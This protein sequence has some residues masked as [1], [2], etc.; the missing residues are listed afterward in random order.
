MKKVAKSLSCVLLALVLT[1]SVAVLPAI[2]AHADEAVDPPV[3]ESAN[4]D[5]NASV[6]EA[7]PAD[8]N[9]SGSSS[10]PTL[11]VLIIAGVVFVALIVVAM[12][13]GLKTGKTIFSLILIAI[14]VVLLVAVTVLYLTGVLSFSAS[15]SGGI[16]SSSEDTTGESG[17]TKP[18]TPELTAENSL[19]LNNMQV[20]L[21]V[22]PTEVE[23]NAAKELVDYVEKMT[24]KVI[25]V[26]NEGSAVEAGIYVGD[27]EFAKTNNVTYP[28][29]EYG[30]GWA[31]KVVD[32]NL[33]L[34]G[35]SVRGTLYAV[36]H[37]LEDALGVHWWTYTEEYV[38]SVEAALVWNEY[39]D[40]GAPA[41]KYREMYPGDLRLV[42][43]MFQVRN[44]INGPTA[45]P[46][47]GF[48]GVEKYGSPVF[49]H[50]FT[51]YV[52]NSMFGDH[53][54]W[55]ALV[56]GERNAQGQL[57]MTNKELVEHMKATLLNYIATDIERCEQNGTALPRWYA[58]VPSD[59]DMFCECENCAAVIE[60]SGLSG[61][62]LQF[63][64]ALAEV[65][66][67]EY[68]DVLVDTL[69]YW[70]YIE[71]PLD[72]TKPADNVVIR[73]AD[74]TMDIFH[75]AS[76][77][78]NADAM[79]WAQKWSE[80]TK[81]G[82][83]FW[84][85]YL[86]TYRQSGPATFMYKF[87]DHF[88]TML[89]TGFVGYFGEM[90]NPI[91]TDFWDMKMWLCAK[92]LEDPYQDF[93]ALLDTFLNGYYGVAGPYVREYL[94]LAEGLVAAEEFLDVQFGEKT[95]QPKWLSLEDAITADEIFNK[96]FEAAKGDRQLQMRLRYARNCLDRAIIE[97][98]E[99]YEH[100]AEEQG[101]DLPLDKLTVCRRLVECIHEQLALRGQY[102]F[103]VTGASDDYGWVARYEDLL[104][105]LESKQ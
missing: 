16:S 22:D 80:L 75:S 81:E 47:A 94:D 101:I 28:S 12:V 86:T 53:P 3:S 55:F 66:A 92:L 63:V 78:N 37:L 29:T 76:H 87:P 36:Y 27:T 56:E 50:T 67:V 46:P 20:V 24:G 72:D 57:C 71:P 79:Q 7:A 59:K 1:L 64:N 8:D 77:E 73:F 2:I 15:S 62:L 89:E 5:A 96:A 26:V 42:E 41:F 31:I 11:I 104:K 84:W 4:A 70:H 105:R 49:V 40:S 10:S 34:C 33:V 9:T 69:A 65:V 32:G 95:Y 82:Q 102:D 99:Y 13:V 74:N 17:Q 18:T 25:P 48:G 35:E 90:E 100:E 44:R 103:T 6:E 19:N 88:Q 23:T 68:P 97:R 83:L 93:E 61:Y 85:D 45:N 43:N 58:I 21:P 51:S 30:E 14:A 39:N 98:F 91:D 60:K 52:P 38:P 54:D